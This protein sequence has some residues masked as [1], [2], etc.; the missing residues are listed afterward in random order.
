[1]KNQSN[2]HL[3][4]AMVF[5][6][7]LI[8]GGL[9]FFG[10]QMRGNAG[11][12]SADVSAVQIEAGI[13]A[14]IARQQKD[15][16]VA[17]AKS[18]EEK[19]TQAKN[20]PPVTDKDHIYGDPEADVTLIE[21]SDFE[22]P[23]CKRFHPTA[24]TLVDESDGKVNWAYR[25][26]PLGFHDPL[27]T[28]QAMASEC[29]AELAGNEAFW[30]YIDAIYETTNSNGRGMTE[31]DLYALAKSAAVNEAD[32]KE[33]FESDRYKSLVQQQMKEGSA[34]GVTGTPGN[35][36]LHNESGEAIAVNG[37]QPL[38]KLQSVVGQLLN[39]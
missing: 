13:E 39:N 8:T 38:T 20:V 12:V 4:F 25:H 29:V 36:L 28:Q 34:S 2:S 1:M 18:D 32:F 33:C 10:L 6:A 5:S 37:A 14:Y 27:A 9:V 15:Q 21:Y 26:F 35:I 7:L 19:Q 16:Q 17:Q 24:K 3:I 23:F 11:M 30:S 31:E 22:C